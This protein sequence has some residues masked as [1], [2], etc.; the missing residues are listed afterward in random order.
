MNINDND[1]FFLIWVQTYIK[2]LTCQKKYT[3]YFSIFA[4]H[5]FQIF[6]PAYLMKRESG[7]NPEQTRYCKS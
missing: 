4:A 6:L 3:K 5:W 2:S 7:E 1:R